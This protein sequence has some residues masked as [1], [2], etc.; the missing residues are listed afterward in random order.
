MLSPPDHSPARQLQIKCQRRLQRQQ[1]SQD[2]KRWKPRE[3]GLEE[4][5]ARD[6]GSAGKRGRKERKEAAKSAAENGFSFC[7]TFC[8]SCSESVAQ[9]QPRL[10]HSL[11]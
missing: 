10:P 8:A 9:R 6:R 5:E 11:R 4:R 2:R 1:Q 3:E 7:L